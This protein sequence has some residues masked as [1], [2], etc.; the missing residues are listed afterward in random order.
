[1][2]TFLTPLAPSRRNVKG[3]IGH[4]FTVHV[5][6]ED[7]NQTSFCPFARR[8]V[9]VLA[10]LVLGHPRCCL[11]D[12]PPQPNSPP[13]YV[14]ISGHAIKTLILSEKGKAG[15]T[16][17][18]ANAP[19]HAGYRQAIPVQMNEQDVVRSSGISRSKG[20][21]KHPLPLLLRLRRRPAKSD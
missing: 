16:R 10:E 18:D 20:T 12:V 19:P 2:V 3:S 1:V 13:D 5:F 15:D 21:I 8:E 17:R 7:S 6:T 14:S 9:S 11:T 4:A